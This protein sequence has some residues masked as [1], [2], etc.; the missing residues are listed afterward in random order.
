MLSDLFFCSGLRV[1]NNSEWFEF[2]WFPHLAGCERAAS[3]APRPRPAHNDVLATNPWLTDMLS[4]SR[5]A[6]PICSSSGLG[7]TCEGQ[8][9][10]RSE[11]R[12]SSRRCIDSERYLRGV[13]A[14]PGPFGGSGDDV[15]VEHFSIAI[16]GGAWTA[17]RAVVDGVRASAS[18]A[19]AKEYCATHHL[20]HSVICCSLKLHG[21]DSC[22]LL[23]KFW[24]FRMGQFLTHR[25]EGGRA[26]CQIWSTD[27]TA[28][29]E[30]PS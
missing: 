1:V 10:T 20:P 6:F 30:P 17:P 27:C 14:P 5:P 7:C 19:H 3:S 24:V 2:A 23:S 18:T 15:G 8:R 9:E 13:A 25:A 21:E 16:R 29:E 11:Q 12:R 22:T 4:A 26:A 28:L